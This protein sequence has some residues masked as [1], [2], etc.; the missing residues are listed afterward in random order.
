MM[1]MYKEG[2]FTPESI[3]QAGL[4]FEKMFEEV[5]VTIKNSHLTNSLLCEMEEISPSVENRY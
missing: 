3:K 5:P 2:D 4:S 1:S